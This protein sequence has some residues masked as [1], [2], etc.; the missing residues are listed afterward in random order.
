[1]GGVATP[2]VTLVEAVSD[3]GVGPCSAQGGGPR[4]AV[5]GDRRG[6]AG[7]AGGREVGLVLSGKFRV[8]LEIS[9][10]S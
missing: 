5:D 10:V 9:T 4:A 3:G 7:C 6:G 2:A 8:W 1:M